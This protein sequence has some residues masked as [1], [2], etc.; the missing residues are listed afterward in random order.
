MFWTDWGSAPKI[1]KA[2]LAGGQRVAIVTTNLKWPN[3]MELDRGNKRIYW[4]DG[5]TDKVESV[6]YQ[7]NN[8]ILLSKVNG[9]HPF[10]VAMIS[11]FLFVT[12]WALG[13]VLHKVDADSGHFIVSNYKTTGRLMGIVSYDQSR[14]PPVAN[15]CAI[16]NGDCSHFCVVTSSSHLCVCPTGFALKQDRRTCEDKVKK[17]F[18]FTDADDKSTNTIS[19]DVNYFAAK[20][21]FSHL[22]NQRPIAL[23]FDPVEDRV[24]W[25]D[26]EQGLIVGAFS[27][28][29]GLKI[30]FRCNI[31]VPDG[32]AIDKVGRNI[33]WS[34]TGTNRIEV[35][36]LDGTKRKLLIKDG[37]D[38]P[39][40]IVLDERNGT[41]YW[42]GWG[43]NPKIEKAA[44]DGS[45]RRSVVT[46]NLGWPNGLTIDRSTNRLYWADAK[47]DKI[48]VSD[49]TGANRQLVVSSAAD[50]HP[51]G[52][53]LYQRMLYWTDWN[54]RSISRLDLSSGNKEMVITGLKKPMDIHLYDST[55][56]ISGSHP[57]GTN[58]GLC[59]DFC[60][61]KPN[62]GYQCACPTGIALKSDGK[63]C[64]Y[65]IYYN[66]SSDH[67]LLFAEANTGEIYK[68]PLEVTDT[69]CEPLAIRDNISRPV[70]VDYD[71]VEG[72]VYWT[73]VT[74]K[75]IVRSFPNGSDLEVLATHNVTNP[76]GLAI[77]WIGRNLYWTD[78]GTSR[79]EVSRLDGSFRTSLITANVDLPRAIIL[80]IEARKMYWSDWGSSPKI[81]KS[82]MDGT[83]RT[84]II[85]SGLTWVNSLALDFKKKVLY[86]CD[87]SLNLIER[88]DLKE[89][90][91]VV[92][93]NLTSDKYHHPFGLALYQDALFWTDWSTQS[94]HKYNMTSATS[95]VLV[96]GMG[97]PMEIHMYDYKTI[98]TGTTSCSHLNGGC[99][100][101]CLPNPTGHRCFC[102]EGVRLK[103]GDQFTCQGVNRC[104]Q[105]SAPV[106][107]S[108]GPC[109]NLPGQACQFSCDQGYVLSGATRRTCNN[110]GAWTGLQTQCN[111]VTCTALKAPS[112]G[113]RQG[114]AG[115]AVE[116]Y[117]TVCLFS[118]SPG[119]NGLGSATRK[120]LHNG[121]WSGHDF[122]CQAISCPSL[123]T[124]PNAITL[125]PCASVYGTS[126]L[127]GCQTGYSSSSGNVTRTCLSSGHWS[128]NDINCTD[129]QA[130]SFG[131]SCPRNLLLSYAEK[132]AFSA[133]VNWT[134][135]VA[136]DNSG[137]TPK[138]SSNFQPPRTFSQ[139]NHVITYT[140]VDQS[141]NKAICRFTVKVIVIRCTS[142]TVTPGGPLRMTSCGNHYGTM[143]NFSCSIGYRMNGSSTVTCSA[144]G[145]QPPG[146]W[147]SPLPTCQAIRCATLPTPSN[148][149][150]TGC[151]DPS[152]EL[153]G[154]ICS[155]SC[156]SGYKLTGSSRRQCLKNESW[157]GM[158]TS[159][160]VISCTPLV[161]PS[162]GMISP[163]SC[164]SRS[165]Y[166]QSC[167]FSC[168]RQG[169]S[170]EGSSVRVC[171]S[172]GE[173][174]GNNDTI[175]KDKVPPSFN[176]SCPGNMVIYL[177]R[178]SPYAQVAWNEPTVTDNS[179]HVIISYPAVRPP[180]N[181]T[182][183]LYSI[184]YSARDDD[185]N[186]ANCS[187][188][189]Q[190]AKKSCPPLQPPMNGAITS[191]SCGSSFG[192]QASLSCNEGYRQ[193]GPI[194]RSCEEDGTWSGNTTTCTAVKC[195]TIKPPSHGT[196]DPSSCKTSSGVV[197][198]THCF[199]SCNAANHYQLEG[200]PEISC[201]QNGSWSA[202]IS[203]V[204]CKDIAP[205]EIK[206][207][208]S[209][210]LP[211][212]PGQSYATATWN[213][214]VPTDNSNEPLNASGLQPPQQFNVGNTNIRYDVTDS[215]GLS[216]SCVFSVDV[217][218][219]E[220][221]L[222]DRCPGDI[223]TISTQRFTKLVLPG[224]KVTDNVGVHNF[225]TNIQNGSE[226]T[227]G[228]HNITYT[229]SDKAGNRAYCRFRITI[230]DSPCED[231]PAPK[232]GG[233]ACEVGLPGL[234]CT[235]HCNPGYG[236]A[237]LPHPLYICGVSGTWFHAYSP[238]G[239]RKPTLPDC[240]KTF[241]PEDALF[242]G[243]YHYLT[244]NCS[245]DT[246]E[247]I[248]AKFKALLFGSRFGQQIC[249]SVPDCQNNIKVDV[250]CGEQTRR[251]RDTTASVP[252]TVNFAVEVPLA[253][254]TDTFLDL[255]DT[256]LQISNDILAALEPAASLNITGVVI[257]VDT[258]RPPEIQLASF[259]CGDGQVLIGTKCVNCPVGYFF[260]SSSCQP[261]AVDE[262]QDQEAQT[263]CIICPPMTSTFGQQG[264]KQRYDCQDLPIQK[265]DNKQKGMSKIK[266]ALI[267]V[268]SALVLLIILGIWL[269]RKYCRK[270]PNRDRSSVNFSNDAY[271]WEELG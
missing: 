205:P 125:T 142:L 229:V 20:R 7:G 11:R 165:T 39:R 249:E 238:D 270:G 31:N 112:N 117:N 67:F 194:V 42:T 182:L 12:D 25:T 43:S 62:E 258:T 23:D 10:G 237:N 252:L 200:P 185:G 247:E 99:S 55:V 145:N 68:I 242:N 102:P 105:L 71:S 50:I 70:A 38:E 35:A 111:A 232:N 133:L 100:H 216:S 2:T 188:I 176:N 209:I 14:Q 98:T 109:S 179:D 241:I 234:I 150:K 271:E 147:D 3:G 132:E 48:E 94:V 207:P 154:T 152:F 79:I 5:G 173:W 106:H 169:Y 158:D 267:I 183:G 66:K 4:V 41:M 30:L 18:L 201:L 167:G 246:T 87:A 189:A 15:Q 9:Y 181:L 22:G 208:P 225:L 146:F 44:M 144:S 60:L 160:Q 245:R 259:V 220:A 263:S 174:T 56:T 57:C 177:P 17:F 149:L 269:G 91:R 264:S 212:E 250:T 64:D 58:R 261:C 248:I 235:V 118:C 101:I 265:P 221:P 159:C 191:L 1:E 203:D 164:L 116:I 137:L 95:E 226:V 36:R 124:A 213:V 148:G 59:S 187:F 141:G 170:L 172:D 178:C 113:N 224:V 231:L 166:G 97:R 156:K 45:S 51:F 96:Y 223:K 128:G 28:A 83:D 88:V 199:L 107:G 16:N 214:P 260:N 47:L 121:S 193:R 219:I 65:D 8:R 104:P 206:C 211:T 153:Y 163:T 204:I 115:T 139:G 143:C 114:C 120:C 202:D 24:Y 134:N 266:L 262:Y 233:K 244:N 92:V 138:V 240:S 155:F 171:G 268:G 75:Q 151:S 180:T 130:P 162:N 93:L 73:D 197:F 37:L 256:S 255:N 77:D 136:T 251:R 34:D 135:P 126:C 6:N 33:Y 254:Y 103:P 196:V 53:T 72:K 82:N 186:S 228:Q 129:S 218:D 210:V 198:K 253:N 90:N 81:E 122:T 217:R 184:H 54:N 29:T 13:G 175:C 227:F 69:P 161:P 222:I 131:V 32:I 89:N 85:S 46:G 190:V 257:V 86:W 108:V 243:Q 239:S 140:A 27:N 26:V 110:D 215:A 63:T 61:L 123:V 192:S 157:S 74:L 78:A 49:L 21:L 19:L 168:Q 230:A 236:F 40:A 80:D 195:A 127:Y 52:L 119:F 84:T 76:D